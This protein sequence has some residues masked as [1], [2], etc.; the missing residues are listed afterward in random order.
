M[1]K[2]TIVSMKRAR[3]KM[4]SVFSVMVAPNRSTDAAANL[5]FDLQLERDLD[6]FLLMLE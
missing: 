5:P 3:A 6:A 4:A 2:P 1:A